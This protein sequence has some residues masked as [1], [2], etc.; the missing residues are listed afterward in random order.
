M[1][2]SQKIVGESMI[3][4]YFSTNNNIDEIKDYQFPPQICGR[5]TPL[6]LSIGF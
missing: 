4:K 6:P 2:C 3:R 1:T 5:R